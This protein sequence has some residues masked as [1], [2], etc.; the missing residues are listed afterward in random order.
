MLN[1]PT[2][3]RWLLS[4]TLGLFLW[5]GVNAQGVTL[6]PST[7]DLGN[8]PI[9]AWQES[10]VFVLQNN[11]AIDITVTEAELE[12]L[13][14]FF[15]VESPALPLVLEAGE[16]MEIGI[17][18]NDR[19]TNG[20]TVNGTLGV[21]YSEDRALVLGDITANAYTPLAANVW[22]TALLVPSNPYTAAAV[23]T[24]GYYNVY[25]LPGDNDGFNRVYRLDLTSDRLL[26]VTLAGADV[27]YALYD[28]TFDGGRGPAADN[29]IV[30]GTTSLNGMPL[31]NGTY[32]LVVSTTGASFDITVN[33]PAMPMPLFATNPVPADG[34][35]DIMNGDVLSWTFG[36]YTEE[37]QLILG[38]T[39]PPSTVVVDWTSDLSNTYALAGLESNMQYFWQ[40]NERNSTGTTNGNIWGF[41]TTLS[42]PL[43][44]TAT[45]VDPT[46]NNPTVSV[47]LAWNSNRAFTGYN[48]YRN[49]VLI[50]PTPITANTFT[51]LNQSRNVTINYAVTAVYD[52]GESDPANASVTT[53]G[54]G[55]VNGLITDELLGTNLAGATISLD[56]EFDYALTSIVNGTYTANVYAGEYDY[57]VSMN[58]FNTETLN[59]VTVAHGAT[60]TNNFSLLEFPY[61]VDFVTA[62]LDGGN[63]NISW[64][65]DARE[66]VEFNIYR[67]KVLLPGSLELIGTTSQNQ[68]VDFDWDEQTWGVYRWAVQAVYTNQVSALAYSNTL[69]M[70]MNTE[71][72]VTV[73]LNS[74]SSPV[75][76][77]VTFTNISEPALNL[78]YTQNLPSSGEYAWTA[79]RKGTYDITVEKPG[80]SSIALNDVNI[81]DETSFEWLLIE[82]L[83]A[84]TDLY[85][86]P[87]GLATWDA[88][89]TDIR[90]FIDYKVFLDGVL[91]ADVADTR[92]QLGTNGEALVDG[93]T[94]LV[95]V[96]AAYSTGQSARTAY[97]FTYIACDNYPAPGAFAAVQV[98]GTVDVNLTWT[99]PTVTGDDQIDFARIYRDGEIIDEVTTASYL[100]EDMAFGEYEYCITFVYESGAE[101]CP[102]TICDE[103]EVIGG[104]F[105]NGN[106]SEAAYLGGE[107]IEG[108]QVII[109]NADNTFT[110][111]TDA[112]GNYTGEVLAGTYNYEVVAEG[113]SSET[114]S[115]V[116][117][118]QTAT[119]TN[120]FI[121]MEFPYAVPQVVAT[122]QGSSALITWNTPGTTPGGGSGINEE[123]DGNIPELLV[124]DTPLSD[125][126]VANDFLNNITGATGVWRSAYYNEEFADFVYEVE[127]QRTS[128]NQTGSMGIYVRGNGFMNPVAGNG[129]TGSVFCITQSGS[130]WYGTLV[131]GDFP[132]WSGWLT[133]SAI[134]TT[135]SNVL[136]AVAQGTTIQY[137][138]NGTLVYTANNV[139]YA[140]GFAG[141]FTN[142]GTTENQ[143][144]VFDYMHL[145]PG[146]VVR[147]ISTNNVSQRTEGT[148]EQVFIPYENTVEPKGADYFVPMTSGSRELTGYNVY[149][150]GCYNSE[151][152]TFL[153]YTLDSTFVDNQWGATAS[154]VYKWGVVAVYD[155]NESEIVFSNCLDKDMITEVS[156]TVIT[157]S[158]D[159]PEGTDVLFTNISEPDLELTYEA[160]LDGTGFIM[161]DEFRKGTYDI[162][163]ELDGFAPI[164]IEG[165]VIDGPEA[166]EFI[167]EELLL[168]VADLYV[169]PT[170]YATWRQGG[171]IPFADFNETFDNGVPET[172]TI[173]DGGTST[174]TWYNETPAGNPQST[175]GSLDGTPFM[176]V[177][178]DEAGSGVTMDEV[179]T[180]PVINASNADELFLHFDQYYNNISTTTE[181][182]RVEVYNGSEW[183]QILNQT[184]DQ[185]AWNN[186][187]H[188][189]ID[190]TEYANEEFQVRFTYYS[191]GWNWYW[192]IDNV[193]VTQTSDSRSLQN[194]KVWL[195]G[196]F[197][198]DTE[199]TFYQ[200]DTENL[201]PGQEYFSEVAA[202]YTN[203]MSEKMNYTWTYYPCDSFPGPQVFTGEV[204]DET[205]VQLTWSNIEPMELVQL[206]QNP[207]APSNGYY[208]QFGYVYGVAYDMSAYPDALVNSV[209]FHHA[210]WGTTG[211]WTY[212]IHIY[213][214]D[215]KTLIST[216]GP[217]TTTGN[218]I[219][220]MGVDLSDIPTGG[221]STVAILMEPTG[222]SA[223][224]AYPD[225]SSDD[226]ADPQG[227]I[228]GSLSDVNSIGSSTIGNFLMEAYILTAYGQVQATPVTFELTSAPAATSRIATRGMFAQGPVTIKQDVNR[229]AG[230]EF[231]GANI[232]RD[233]ILIAEM[234][235]DTSYLDEAVEP[236]IHEYCIKYV[237]ES[238]AMS[239]GDC[240]EVSLAEEC[241]PPQDLTA[242]IDDEETEI[243]LTWN[244][245]AGL[246]MSY[247]DLV[248]ADAIGLTDF[249]PVTVAIQWD[250][251]DLADYDGRAFTKFKFY[252]G[253][254][255]IGTVKAQVWEGTTLVLEETVTSPIV[256]E[257][258]NEYE[259]IDPVVIDATKSYRLG[260]TVEG[261]DA[262]PAGAQNFTGDLNSDLVML[263]GAWDNLSN[264]LAYSW[265]IETF[266]GQAPA[267]AVNSPVESSV[268]YPTTA[269][270]LASAP[271]VNLDR[272]NVGREVS[273][274]LGY[275]VYRDGEQINDAIVT[276]TTYIDTEFPNGDVCYTVT[277]VYS[278]CGES[279]ESNE[280]CILGINT[281]DQNLSQVRIYPNPANSILNIELT[282]NVERVLVYNYT[283]QVVVEQN[284]VDSTMRI[285]VNNFEAGAYLVKL[286]SVD[287]NSV[288][289]KVIITK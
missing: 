127:L 173:T 214:W 273:A 132:D 11:S 274:F 153:G 257:S 247:G 13:T 91:V 112:A 136:T 86:T 169:T 216:L 209:D 1:K 12:D 143:T 235:T 37:F 76:T 237:Y 192:A 227:S 268:V 244:T 190:V 102:A 105:V 115:N 5:T 226:A 203:G 233:G 210:S 196:M 98:L 75:G 55:V 179:L 59:D 176:M 204:I 116:V 52:E 279:E 163:V 126:T 197:I 289:K 139:P 151:E 19:A 212:N 255:S 38:T 43:G 215:T 218:D 8:R 82:D 58:G 33:A 60:V 168:P 101:T 133:S 188:Q 95:E 201:V 181:Y 164:S 171:E 103:V 31:F 202:V 94:Y 253:T 122:D 148:L 198:A 45:V 207:G 80:Y 54:V 186:P 174:D 128:G 262:Y 194:Y 92:Y 282:S 104:G 107:N 242:V 231:V 239:C 93:Q 87:T 166:F 27:K 149:R 41:T 39:Y 18:T 199:N 40:I 71:V 23:P 123:F 189:V 228:Y 161:W 30:S 287:G 25:D 121:L 26:Y 15:E 165:Y 67:E 193:A 29:A 114:L 81:F 130:Y 240:I 50:T 10:G 276:E 288:T 154:G 6:T 283:G 85:V 229:M 14:G 24:T 4:L 271:S 252:Y 222:N 278:I 62:T 211:T 246:W 99:V 236:G 155:E 35:I 74:N 65:F 152:L 68:F 267:A 219:W 119:V 106:V 150:T 42:I 83:D 49:G 158:Q 144:T 79:F 120:N 64:G 251:E 180:S 206:T 217:F 88:V 21:V 53:R 248:Y 89:E 221:A 159:S 172:W 254:G 277:A 134:N 256:G 70:D 28:E 48:V 286:I 185:G 156:V 117:I 280:A 208:Q 22:E 141:L 66:L 269:A 258:W 111:T 177:D 224:D 140:S 7:L 63:V 100:D 110:F 170:G 20:Q 200:Y 32:Y 265:L 195:D 284:A 272:G 3:L 243:V 77:V 108:A 259:Y 250:P 109:S 275:N 249:S 135:G 225:L 160:E 270:S 147:N 234:L 184:S 51:D 178:S 113:Y 90:A 125:W 69:D 124:L 78:V 137:L 232:Y 205:D 34:A 84:P 213:N 187:D 142:T 241:T 146:A 175:N 72:D 118:A 182:A 285:D 17:T 263:D 138:I 183:I 129:T 2:F 57:T 238:G 36:Q 264:Y 44:L 97:T 167:L 191:T 266:I 47:D 245:F 16:T 131:N 61:A 46:P 145:T 157:D 281:K 73:T 96:A 230:D 56:G 260:Y 9:G 261:Y 223:T 220:E 162:L